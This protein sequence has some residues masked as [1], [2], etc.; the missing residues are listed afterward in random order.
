MAM[1]W[2]DA[3]S[4][5][6]VKFKQELRADL[7]VTDVLPGKKGKKYEHIAGS[8]TM[9]TRDRKLT[10]NVAGMS[11]DLR[12]WFMKNKEEAKGTIWEVLYNGIVKARGSDVYKLFLPRLEHQRLDKNE[13]NSLEELQEAATE[14]SL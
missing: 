10:V 4:K 11:D 12:E 13:A 8:V 6:Q 2:E 1:L 3:R 7:E 5:D 14:A 9:V